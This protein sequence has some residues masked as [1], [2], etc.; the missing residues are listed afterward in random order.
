VH[1][2]LAPLQPFLSAAHQLLLR[3]RRRMDTARFDTDGRITTRRP[4]PR[5]RR[6][7]FRAPLLPCCA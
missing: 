4:R 1:V 5:N 2:G 6:L 7:G 3:A